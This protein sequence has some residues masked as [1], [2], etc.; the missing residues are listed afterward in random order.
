MLKQLMQR[1][2]QVLQYLLNFYPPYFGAGVRITRLDL[3]HGNIDIKMP[4]TR[5]NKNYVGTQFGGSLYSMID[6]F[7]MFILMHHMGSGYVVWDKG[8]KI[9]F[10]APGRGTVYAK[11]RLTLEQIAEVKTAAATGEK[12]LRDYPVDITDDSGQVVA[13]IIKTLYIRQKRPQ[14]T[15]Q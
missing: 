9:D 6:P 10:V 15:A 4:L 1:K 8:A 2:P 7:F 5:L 11:V 3:E 14:A 12:V 13:H